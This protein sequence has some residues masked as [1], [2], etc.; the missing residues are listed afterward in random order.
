VCASPNN[1]VRQTCTTAAAHLYFLSVQQGSRL[2]MSSAARFTGAR[3]R[4]PQ[5]RISLRPMPCTSFRLVLRRLFAQ[6]ALDFLVGLYVAH[7]KRR[8]AAR[9][10]LLSK[11]FGGGDCGFALGRDRISPAGRQFARATSRAI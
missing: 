4:Q 3:P 11:R 2:L 7:R 10:F 6:Q 8:D 1:A 9:L 5:T